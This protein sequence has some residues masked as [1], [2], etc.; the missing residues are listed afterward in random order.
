MKRVQ[1]RP[2]S[3][4][5]KPLTERRPVWLVGN[6]DGHIVGPYHAA[7]AAQTVDERRARKGRSFSELQQAE[8]YGFESRPEGR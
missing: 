3:R 5:R 4:C 8:L 1:P 2:C 7:C 6:T